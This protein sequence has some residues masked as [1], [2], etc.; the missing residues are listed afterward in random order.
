MTDGVLKTILDDET[1]L[2]G[3]SVIDTVSEEF[4]CVFDKLLEIQ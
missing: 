2:I 4:D 3:S 1:R